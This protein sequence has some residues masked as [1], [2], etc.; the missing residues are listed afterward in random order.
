MAIS[1]ESMRARIRSVDFIRKSVADK[2]HTDACFGL[3]KELEKQ[4]TISLGPLR[5]FDGS[6][7]LGSPLETSEAA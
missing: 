2:V 3:I 6:P 4:S 1:S 7:L 5:D